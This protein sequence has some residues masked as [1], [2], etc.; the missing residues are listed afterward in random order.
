MA[1]LPETRAED[2]RHGGFGI[3]I[4]WPFC[5]AKCPYCDFNSHVSNRIDT[6][7]WQRAYLAEIDRQAELAPDRVLNSIFFGGGT[8]SLMPAEMVDAVLGR[9]R[10]H[11]PFAN[12]MEITLEA[13][14]GSTD[15]ARFRGYSEA[16]VNRLSLGVQ[17]LNARDLAR[18]GRIHS[19]EQALTAFDTARDAFGRVSFD[20]I[21]ARQDQG[22]P[23]WEAELRR[24]LSLAVDHISLYQL[25]VEPGTAFEDRFRR[26]GLRG[27]PSEDL[28]ADLY[29]TTQRIA[30]EFGF[31]AYEVSNLARPGA[32]SRHNQI[33]WRYGDY[34]GIGPGAHGRITR[35][36]TKFATEAHRMPDAWLNAVDR[37]TGDTAFDALTPDEAGA[38]MLMMG[39]RLTEG[40]DLD[41]FAGLTGRPLPENRIAAA[42]EIGML[43][44]DG[45][46][47][48]ATAEGR[49]V[50]NA[51]IAD[52]LR[53]F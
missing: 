51:L 2:W 36:G 14:P 42:E 38:E 16:G 29:E 5:L 52:L 33:Y 18:L 49:L 19:V 21:Y 10:R 35:D 1:A 22:L 9:I 20:L 27:L 6:E 34:L 17:A 39:L 48:A 11:W 12:D 8:P 53:D 50:L 23:E 28:S 13:N 43:R 47:I 44:R 41:R 46:R 3:Y 4:H 26:G 31:S 30:G 7:R 15:A 40:V 24:A 37:G 25:T 32:E 45:A